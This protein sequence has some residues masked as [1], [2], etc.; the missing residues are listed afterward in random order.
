MWT[1]NDIYFKCSIFVDLSLYCFFSLGWLWNERFNFSTGFIRNASTKSIW[2]FILGCECFLNKW[3]SSS[4]SLRV[5]NHR[6]NVYVDSKSIRSSADNWPDRVLSSLKISPLDF[7]TNIWS[8]YCLS[9]EV[10]FVNRCTGVSALHIS[11][12]QSSGRIASCPSCS[13][14]SRSEE[15]LQ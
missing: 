13:S 4:S 1:S 3:L 11:I 2:L 14:C 6:R 12:S 15:V 8:G 9:A 10:F 7:K 5:L